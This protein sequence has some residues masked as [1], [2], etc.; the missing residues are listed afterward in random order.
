MMLTNT[1]IA[2]NVYNTILDNLTEVIQSTLNHHMLANS[3]QHEFT[4]HTDRI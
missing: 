3:D 1:H 2:E 4:Y